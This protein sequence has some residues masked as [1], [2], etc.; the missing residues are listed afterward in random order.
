MTNLNYDIDYCGDFFIINID[1][2][3]I[4]DNSIKELLLDVYNTLEKSKNIILNL[5]K[6]SYLNSIGLNCLISI[7][8]K[9]RIKGGETIITNV[10]EDVKKLLLITKLNTV[11]EIKNTIEEAKKELS[12]I[13]S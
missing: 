13:K 6:L 12:L 9:S 11:F 8:T 2:K 4:D 5:E 3:I 7:L 10:S 1:G